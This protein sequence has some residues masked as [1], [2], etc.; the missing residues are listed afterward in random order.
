MEAAEKCYTYMVRCSDGTLW[1][2]TVNGVAVKT[3]KG[4][5]Q[6]IPILSDNRSISR[7]METGRGSLLATNTSSLFRFDPD[8]RVLRPV[9]RDLNAFTSDLVLDREDRLWVPG[10]QGLDCYETV[11]FTK[12]ISVPV[13]FP[14]YHLSSIGNGE[15]WMSG[16]GR[17]SIYDTREMQFKEIP[18]A[19]RSTPRIMHGDVE[20][21]EIQYVSISK[22]LEGFE[23]IEA[24]HLFHL[25][26]EKI[27]TFLH[28][29]SIVHSMVRFKDGATI[30]Q[31][32][33][34]DMRLQE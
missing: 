28:R 24:K 27:Q 4:S 22:N 25:S 11:T 17:I 16:M 21:A 18:E 31:L 14:V 33:L 13:Q 10:Q 26:F 34:P 30:A 1:V 3:D 8:E 20:A 32:S 19:I 6:R 7:I 15:L 23:V 9:V 29:E 2:A 5:F 12:I